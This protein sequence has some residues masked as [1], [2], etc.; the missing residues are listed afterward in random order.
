MIRLG[1]KLFLFSMLFML[2]LL[3]TFGM[4]D[5][6]AC[7][8]ANPAYSDLAA[9]EKTLTILKD[10]VG[11]NTATYSISLDT[12][13][14]DLYSESLPQEDAQYTL[15]SD[16]SKV[17]VICNFVNQKL[18][19][20][21][22]HA[23]DGSI[24]MTQPCT[25]V[26]DTAKAFLDK[27]QAYSEAFYIE[28]MRSMLDTVDANR[29]VTKTAENTKL[30]VIVNP[31]STTFRWTPAVNGI[32]VMLKWVILSFENGSPAFFMDNWEL[33]NIGSYDITISEEEAIDIAMKATENYS[34]T[35]NMGG[36][37]PPVEVTEFTV[38]GVSETKLTFCNYPSKNE[39]RNGD[40]L[41]LY[42]SWNIK[43]YFDKFYRGNVYGVNIAIW[44]DTGEVNDI[45]PMMWMGEY[46]SDGNIN[47]NETASGLKST[48]ES[49]DETNPSLT[50]IVWIALPITV[51]LAVTVVYSKRKITPNELHK[52]PKSN[53]LKLSGVLL[54]LLMA[55]S[56]FSMVPQ[57]VKADDRGLICW[58]I[59]W[60]LID[61]ESS[62][63]QSVI[64]TMISYFGNRGYTCYN[65]YG[66]QTKREN[67]LDHATAMEENFDNVAM[68]HYGHGGLDMDYQE[69]RD[70]ID[71]DWEDDP[72]E[73][74]EVWD[75]DVYQ[76]TGSSKHFFVM[77]WVCRQGDHIGGLGG[78]YGAY[79]MP[80]A[81]HHTSP[82]SY[83][84]DCFIGFK[85]T[86]MPLTQVSSHNPSIDYEFF[87][88][89]FY[90]LALHNGYTVYNSLNVNSWLWFGCSYY[91]SELHTG[92]TGDWGDYGNGTG[93]MKIYGNKNIY[94]Y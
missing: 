51:V 1:K 67:V 31:N 68:F 65:C 75:Y 74:N 41:T 61:G 32:D 73:D 12:H 17:E 64:S 53:Y 48:E 87:I 23:L 42:P 70:Y 80:Y 44:A 27:Y 92:F 88:Q 49:D 59:T 86:S 84:P 93:Y 39:S 14:Q 38:E 72:S 66:S 90:V 62:A 2:G 85:D 91:S 79:G 77:L 9:P 4:Y 24:R 6:L 47:D 69:H 83:G 43:L 54:C 37:N 13:T 82:T 55:F 58:G 50:A 34:W 36:D 46:S 8:A 89:R 94:L 10:V 28:D 18:Q 71:D 20:I 3:V 30:E 22:L 25:D 16:E 15:V 76:H 7:S 26:L 11:L 56:M 21:S 5:S 33:Y 40:P 78:H 63:A 57:I 52:A 45:R 29:N 35:V 60:E 19:L 81:W